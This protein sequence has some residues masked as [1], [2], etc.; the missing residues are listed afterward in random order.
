MKHGSLVKTLV[1]AS[2]TGKARKTVI[3]PNFHCAN[4]AVSPNVHLDN[5]HATVS[6]ENRLKVDAFFFFC[7]TQ[8]LAQEVP[9]DLWMYCIS[10]I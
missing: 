7:K 1:I 2:D 10:T 4:D 5:L 8:I 3:T 9:Q 6:R